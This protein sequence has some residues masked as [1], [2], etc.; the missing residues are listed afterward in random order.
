MTSTVPHQ[1]SNKIAL[2]RISTRVVITEAICLVIAI[3]LKIAISVHATYVR[4]KTREEIGFLRER[5]VVEALTK[6]SE[7]ECLLHKQLIR[8][9]YRLLTILQTNKNFRGMIEYKRMIA[10]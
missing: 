5:G 3:L 2:V 1:N 6:T 9:W 10:P 4:N 8:L 7:E